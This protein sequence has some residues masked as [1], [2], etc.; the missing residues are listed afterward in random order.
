MTEAL[1]Q[2]CQLVSRWRLEAS[3]ADMTGDEPRSALF[4]R[5]AGELD[6]LVAARLPTDDAALVKGLALHMREAQEQVEIASQAIERAGNL[7]HLDVVNAARGEGEGEAAPCYECGSTERFGTAC[8]P[9]NPDLAPLGWTGGWRPDLEAAARIVDPEIFE[10]AKDFPKVIGL[11][12][13]NRAFAKARAILALPAA[14]PAPFAS[15]PT[16]DEK[17][18]AL[19]DALEA[20]VTLCEWFGQREQGRP[21]TN[22]EVRLFERVSNVSGRLEAMYGL[23]MPDLSAAE[24]PTEPPAAPHQGEALPADV[25]RLVIAAREVAFNE[26][27]LMDDNDRERFAELD[28]ASEAFADRVPWEDEPSLGEA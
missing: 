14:P 22:S 5:V 8:A 1:Q 26:A 19:L 17:D 15:K 23:D 3:V 9:C 25:V 18:M 6:L 21:T 7:L 11:S 27:A 4:S 12:R 2:L 10:Q 20:M 24:P 28:A 13:W 16:L